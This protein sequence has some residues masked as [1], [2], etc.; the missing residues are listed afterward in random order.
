M[1][2][3]NGIEK[4]GVEV[5][6]HN[7]KVGWDDS[8]NY[9]I[10]YS[11][12][13]ENPWQWLFWALLG[14]DENGMEQIEYEHQCWTDRAFAF[15]IRNPLQNF[16]HYALGI[17]PYSDVTDYGLDYDTDYE[18][19][20]GERYDTYNKGLHLLWMRTLK[21]HKHSLIPN[22]FRVPFFTSKI[23]TLGYKRAGNFGM[24]LNL[25]GN[26]SIG[27]IENN[28]RYWLLYLYVIPFFVLVMGLQAA[29]YVVSLLLWFLVLI[30]S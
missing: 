2:W 6:S 11:P 8:K 30:S 22:K 19:S 26:H 29:L 15:W 17:D 21:K 9:Y 16:N 27:T 13:S 7:F 20:T 28:N 24:G 23:A 5:I 1:N 12:I 14:N 4:L 10:P 3:R 18:F 25:T